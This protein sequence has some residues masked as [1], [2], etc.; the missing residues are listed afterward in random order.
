[1]Y[2]KLIEIQPN[3]DPFLFIDKIVECNEEKNSITK[4][5]LSKNEWFFKCHWENDPNM[6]AM[7]QLETMSQTASLCLFSKSKPPEKLYLTRIES[8]SFR[9]KIIPE[10]T[11]EISSTQLKRVKN[12]YTY[13]CVIRDFHKRNLISKSYL[14]LLWPTM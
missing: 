2:K 13:K 7:L 12:V 6:P 9:K 1:M 14:D 8:A 11:I 5:Y 4:K 3:R 10:M